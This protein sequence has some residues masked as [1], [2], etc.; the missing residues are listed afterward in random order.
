MEKASYCCAKEQK[1][2][3]A[4]SEVKP[5]AKRK[6]YDPCGEGE[7]TLGDLA[8]WG[9][10]AGAVMLEEYQRESCQQQQFAKQ[11]PASKFAEDHHPKED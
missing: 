7:A 8:N 10:D 1:R 9:R 11:E 5:K 6:R 4:R 2:I 3:R